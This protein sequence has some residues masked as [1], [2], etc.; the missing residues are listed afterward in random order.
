MATKDNSLT[1]N[2]R[3]N[4]A[5]FVALI[6]AFLFGISATGKPVQAADPGSPPKR[7]LVVL[8]H[9]QGCKVCAKIK[10]I[11]DELRNEYKTKADF[12]D[13]EVTDQKTI[14]Q[15]RKTAKD[16]NVSFFLS[17]YEDNFPAVGVFNERRKCTK[18]LYGLN[19]R[20]DYKAAIDEAV[21][22]AEKAAAADTGK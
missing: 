20:E 7:A 18:E 1:I 2:C 22:S 9:A 3:S 12:V 4:L 13:L 21:A 8:V 16:L 14:K 5:M 10:P 6:G 19:K 17:F 15:S 11:V